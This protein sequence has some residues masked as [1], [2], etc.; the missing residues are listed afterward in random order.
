MLAAHHGNI[1]MVSLLIQRGAEPEIAD[2]EG[3]TA[4]VRAS[5][6]GH[7]EIA[8]LL[9]L[10]DVEGVSSPFRLCRDFIP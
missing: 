6:R 3:R 4:L 2:T 7:L 9:L 8:R 5:R 1:D 10:A